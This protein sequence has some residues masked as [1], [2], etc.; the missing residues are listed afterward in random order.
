MEG[1]E[2]L[3]AVVADSDPV[4][5]GSKGVGTFFKAVTQAVLFF[6]AEMWVLTPRMEQAL[7]R[8]KI[9]L[10]DG[11]LGGSQG[12][13]GLVVGSTHHCRKQWW[14]QASRG[15]EHTSQ[16]GRTRSLSIL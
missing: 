1:E 7:S 3:G 15:S 4:G 8:F 16:G 10:R 6:G 14:N 2:E 9:G 5:G 13:G 11:S 12:Y